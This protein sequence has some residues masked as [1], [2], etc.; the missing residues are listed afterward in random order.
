MKKPK[1]SVIMPVYN[2]EKYVRQTIDCILNQTYS[3]FEL[4]I[5]DDCSTDGTMDIV[6]QIEDNRIRIIHNEKNS[7]IAHSRNVGLENANGEYIALMDNDDLSPLNRFEKEVEYLDKHLD[8]GV[9][10]GSVISI[11]EEGEDISCAVKM[12]SNPLELWVDI[13]FACPI[14]NSSTMFRREIVEK[15]NIRYHDGMLGMED[16]DFWMEMSSVSKIYNFSDVFLK[17]RISSGSETTR[18]RTNKVRERAEKF[19]EIQR[20]GLEARG[21]KLSE[22]EQIIF[23]EVFD[24]HKNSL[25]KN[26]DNVYCVLKKIYFG[27]IEVYPEKEETTRYVLRNRFIQAINRSNMQIKNALGAKGFSSNCFSSQPLVSVIIPTHNRADKIEMSINSVLNQTY[28]NIEIIIVDDCSS[29]NTKN[30]IEKIILENSYIKFYQ[31]KEN[32]GPAKAR[33][34]G[35]QHANGEYIAFHDDDDEWHSDKLEIQMCC[36]LANKEIDMTFGKMARYRNR[37]FLNIVNQDLDWDRLKENFFQEI[38]LDNYVGAPTIV[39]KKN[40]FDKI[41]GFNENLKCIEDWE[42]AIRAFKFLLVEFIPT[43]LMDVHVHDNSVTNNINGYIESWLYIFKQYS[44]YT[45]NRNKYILQMFAHLKANAVNGVNDNKKKEVLEKI[46]KELC[47][48]YIKEELVVDIQFQ[49]VNMY[50]IESG[51]PDFVYQRMVRYKNTCIKLLTPEKRIARWLIEK[52]YT[53]I[54]VYGIGRLGK[55][56]IDRLS[57]TE[58]IIT[59]MIDRNKGQYQGKEVY[60]LDEFFQIASD[61]ELVIITPLYEAQAI[62][63]SIKEHV[64]VDYISVEELLVD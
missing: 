50:N 54:A 36:M 64:G 58:I 57:G 21:I 9:V 27:I 22:E 31:L 35:V 18:I 3:D 41:G 37:V 38:L 53:N 20:K 28:Q 55:C 59:H 23:K 30:V 13:L 39:M 63:Q 45:N 56:L 40:S 33:N 5:I 11:N 4:L 60:S 24:E 7:G 62:G 26:L 52:G 8:I 15:N 16:Y 6:N 29:D 10:G 47:P 19:F 12:I 49:N 48:A 32:G 42:F 44:S 51:N 34:Y 2:A 25:I 17:W 43:P 14:A 46:K 1:I 61:T